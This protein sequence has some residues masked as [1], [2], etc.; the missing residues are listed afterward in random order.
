MKR[1]A[2]LEQ[3]GLASLRLN[4][5][6]L[7]GRLT[8]RP[9]DRAAAWELYVELATRITT[10][11]LPDQDGDEKT[12]LESVAGLFPLPR[13]VLKRHGPACAEC[14]RL[15]I[16]VLNQ[17]VR[18][19]T[20]KWHKLSLDGKFKQPARCAEFREELVT[21]QTTLRNYA[22]AL[23]ALANVEDWT[24]LEAN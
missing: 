16:P 3:W 9:A 21:L 10:Q 14:A 1:R 2:F 7:A 22:Q 24:A 19:F 6:T 17:C 4:P 5:D 13:D 15:A 20:A 11:P 12:A 23:A 8:P 18:P